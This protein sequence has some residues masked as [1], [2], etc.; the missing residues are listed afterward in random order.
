MIAWGLV[1]RQQLIESEMRRA[2]DEGMS[3]DDPIYRDMA[4]EW[5]ELQRQIDEMNNLNK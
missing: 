3:Y 2:D 5:D 4:A 1:K